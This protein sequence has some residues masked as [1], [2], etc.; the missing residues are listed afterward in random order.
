MLHARSESIISARCFEKL[1]YGLPALLQ[2][3]CRAYCRGKVWLAD[4]LMSRRAEDTP[5]LC[6]AAE[7]AIP[8]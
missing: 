1:L 5:E 3:R 7:C 2:S 6:L 8:F 4:M